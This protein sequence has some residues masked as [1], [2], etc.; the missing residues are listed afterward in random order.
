[1]IPEEG[2]N[3]DEPV[4]WK[5]IK[6]FLF[7]VCTPVVQIDQ[8]PHFRLSELIFRKCETKSTL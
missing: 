6:H 7:G 5:K 4:F 3:E 2:I 1:M 8:R